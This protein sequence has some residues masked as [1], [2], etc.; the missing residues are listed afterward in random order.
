MLIAFWQILS[1]QENYSI[2][3]T[4]TGVSTIFLALAFS[5][6]FGR[7]E[8]VVSN[9]NN[10]SEQE[11]IPYRGVEMKRM[12]PISRRRGSHINMFEF[13]NDNRAGIRKA[14]WREKRE[15]TVNEPLQKA[16][17]RACPRCGGSAGH[18]CPCKYRS[19]Y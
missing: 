19:K 7:N 1:S 11:K 10:R 18:V 14:R 9:W 6:F 12:Y 13:I 16:H 15:L 3:V 4:I 8:L 5:M 17:S 2:L